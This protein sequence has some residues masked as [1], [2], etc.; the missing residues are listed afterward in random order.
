MRVVGRLRGHFRR[1]R[2]A[3]EINDAELTRGGFIFDWGEAE[4]GQKVAVERQRKGQSLTGDYAVD[5][6][7]ISS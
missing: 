7:C 6:K 3:N 1:L 5:G 4:G 2:A